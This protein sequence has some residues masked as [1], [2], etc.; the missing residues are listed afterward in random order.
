VVLTREG[1]DRYFTQVFA[2]TLRRDASGSIAPDTLDEA[3][4]FC[5][6]PVV[7]SGTIGPENLGAMT[8][9]F[10]AAYDLKRGGAFPSP[11]TLEFMRQRSVCWMAA[12]RTFSEDV[13]VGT[14]F[15]FV[16]GL[17]GGLGIAAYNAAVGAA[18]AATRWHMR[19][20]APPP[21]C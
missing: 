16:S 14:S 19:P 4:T 11:Q 9:P 21:G 20:P 5:V 7:T 6:E 17:P 15:G 1:S 10:S 3:S 18:L 2:L 12:V 8:V 13:G